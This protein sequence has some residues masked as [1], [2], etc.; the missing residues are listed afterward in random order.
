M[1]IYSDS[2]QVAAAWAEFNGDSDAVRD[3]Y[4]CSSIADNGT[5]DY[6]FNFSTN[7]TDADYVCVGSVVGSGG[8]YHSVITSDGV[9][10][11]S[12]LCRFRVRH[13][14]DSSQELSYVQVAIFR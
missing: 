8:G 1:A 7:M 2:G 6:G 9:G 4:N 10:K 5:G 13:V 3:S 11:T 14:N 12:S